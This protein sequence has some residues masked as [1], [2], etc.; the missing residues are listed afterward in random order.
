ML[1][2]VVQYKTI[3]WWACNCPTLGVT[4]ADTTQTH[5][6]SHHIAQFPIQ[7]LYSNGNLFTKGTTV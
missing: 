4:L 3:L 5:P 6:I 1:I 7:Q 2:T